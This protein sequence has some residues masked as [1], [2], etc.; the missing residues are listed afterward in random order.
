MKSYIA[1]GSRLQPAAEP[2]GVLAVDEAAAARLLSLSPRTLWGLRH[3]G[4]G[5]AHVRIGSSVRYS[6]A[7]LRRW[8][9]EQQ[10]LSTT[11]NEAGGI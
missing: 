11:T 3:D 7:E 10:A 6:V 1:G 9:A 8:L 4:R 2:A 5:P